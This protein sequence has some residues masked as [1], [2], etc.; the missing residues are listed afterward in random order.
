SYYRED[1]LSEALTHLDAAVK[2][3][4][5]AVNTVRA[6]HLRGQVLQELGQ[7]KDAVRAFEQALSV[8]ATADETLEVLVRL[9]REQV[10]LNEALSYLR[11][12]VLAVSDDHEGLLKAA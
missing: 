7:P 5:E 1:K 8:D 2:A 3:D 4:A 12:Y 6:H 9:E 11:R 10:H